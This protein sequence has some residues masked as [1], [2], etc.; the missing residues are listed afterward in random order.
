MLN[1][2]YNC[3]SSCITLTIVV[4]L[5]RAKQSFVAF[6]ILSGTE[7][8]IIKG[9]AS[10]IRSSLLAVFDANKALAELLLQK[11][12]ADVQDE[13][14]GVDELALDE[15]LH[16]KE[17]VTK[18]IRSTLENMDDFVFWFTIRCS[19]VTREPLTALLA[20]MSS[21]GP[22]GLS[23]G[24]CCADQLPIVKLICTRCGQVKQLFM[25]LFETFEVWFA[26]TLAFAHSTMHGVQD[27]VQAKDILS[28]RPEREIDFLR[29]MAFELLLHNYTA[30]TR[31]IVQPLS[32]SLVSLVSFTWCGQEFEYMDSTN[33]KQWTCVIFS[34]I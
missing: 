30:F 20:M 23:K 6:D 9:P 33:N 17:K 31:R 11:Q 5:S 15:R 14:A 13:D 12:R 26:E 24:S 25:E 2:C 3:N 19:F 1:N 7:E 22:E 28:E 16:Y 29:H 4:K 10:R 34:V 21:D 8:F 18:W 32:Q 27:G